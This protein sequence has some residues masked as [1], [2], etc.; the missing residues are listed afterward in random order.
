MSG[1]KELSKSDFDSSISKGKWAIDFWAAWCGPC[2]MMAPHFEAA[3]EEM[4]DVTFAKLDVQANS[5]LA[6]KYEVMGIPCI[7]FFK[8][9][10]EAGRSVGLI[11]KDEII[12]R[13]KQSLD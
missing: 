1:L 13:V 3:A 8:D 4:K 7:I 9:G 5:E 2:R 10:K 6:Q 11:E 12:D